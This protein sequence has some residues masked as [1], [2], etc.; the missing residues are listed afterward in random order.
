MRE[1]SLSGSVNLNVIDIRTKSGFEIF[2]GL[3]YQGSICP[4]GDKIGSSYR[5]FRE[6]EGS[7]NRG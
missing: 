1:N 6:M 7:R 4:M 5:E 2:A 3:S